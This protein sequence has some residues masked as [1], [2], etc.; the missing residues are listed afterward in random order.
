MADGVEDERQ[1]EAEEATDAG[2]IEPSGELDEVFRLRGA[3][4]GE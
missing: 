4:P 3:A 1:D 2:A